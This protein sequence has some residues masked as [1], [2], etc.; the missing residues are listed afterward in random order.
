MIDTSGNTSGSG[1]LTFLTST[2]AFD[3]TPP[4]LP[5]ST[6]L[7]KTSTTLKLHLVAGEVLKKLKTRYRVVGTTTWTEQVIIPT[8]L[9][10]DINLS[11]LLSGQLYEYQYV[12]EDGSGNQALTEWVGV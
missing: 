9:A 2:P 3:E 8:A 6:L 10:F 1:N 11:G 7:E 4:A 12:L 5:Q